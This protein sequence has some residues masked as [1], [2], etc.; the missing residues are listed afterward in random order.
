MYARCSASYLVAG[1]PIE[2]TQEELHIWFEH[3]LMGSGSQMKK[4]LHIRYCLP[5]TGTPR[6]ITWE[7]EEKT[8]QKTKMLEL[9]LNF[10]LA[11]VP[12]F[13]FVF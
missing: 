3:V 8:D 5:T 11:A 12:Y 13:T 6:E 10:I 7:V 9:I 4:L 1:Y 2:M